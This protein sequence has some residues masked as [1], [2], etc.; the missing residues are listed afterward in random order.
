M[1]VTSFG[2]T[3]TTAVVSQDDKLLIVQFC[4]CGHVYNMRRSKVVELIGTKQLDDI[5]DG[6]KLDAP[7]LS[8]TDCQDC[9]DERGRQERLC[10]EMDLGVFEEPRCWTCHATGVPLSGWGPFCSAE[11]RQRADHA[12]DEAAENR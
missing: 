10:R 8:S 11:C 5:A 9:K 12:A 2:A 3:E 7:I 4:P 1:I 6:K